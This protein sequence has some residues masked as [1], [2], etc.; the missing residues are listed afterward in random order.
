MGGRC[1]LRQR[2]GPS[3][4]WGGEVQRDRML[5]CTPLRNGPSA[6]AEEAGRGPDIV[7]RE[8]PRPGCLAPSPSLLLNSHLGTRPQSPGGKEHCTRTARKT[9]FPPS[10]SLPPHAASARGTPWRGGAAGRASSRSQ[11]VPGPSRGS[12]LEATVSQPRSSLC[13]VSVSGLWCFGRCPLRPSFNPELVPRS[14]C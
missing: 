12:T 14:C 8:R 11:H 10:P 6:V 3:S 9:L 5:R 7:R 4:R 2:P 1:D 13:E